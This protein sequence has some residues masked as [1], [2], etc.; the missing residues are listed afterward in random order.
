[1]ERREASGQREAAEIA[2]VIPEE[3]QVGHSGSSEP[4]SSADGA[5]NFADE[6]ERHNAPAIRREAGTLR[7]QNPHGYN[8][9]FEGDDFSPRSGES[10]DYDDD[11]DDDDG[12][13]SDSEE[14]EFLRRSEKLQTSLSEPYAPLSQQGALLYGETITFSE[15]NLV[16]FGG[17]LV[18]GPQYMQMVGALCLATAPVVLLTVIFRNCLQGGLM[19]ATWLSWLATAVTLVWTSVT[20]PAIIPKRMEQMHTNPPRIR[21]YISNKETNIRFCATCEIYRGPRSHHC[22]ICGNCVDQYDHHC[23]WTGTCIGAGNYHIFLYFL[24]TLHFEAAFV[25]IDATVATINLSR[26]NNISVNEALKDLY[27]IPI[28]LY[29][30][31]FAAGFSITGLMLFHW[32]LIVRNLTTA[33]FLKCVYEVE[34]DNPW[35][36]GV[37]NNIVAKFSGWCDSRTLAWNYEA[38]LVK[39]IVKQE[40]GLLTEERE[41][42]L[43]AKR[44][45]LRRHQLL[46]QPHPRHGATSD[47]QQT[48]REDERAFPAPTIAGPNTGLFL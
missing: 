40:L 18:L 21:Q 10:A 30:F 12:I 19:A 32:F 16:F 45:E 29:F 46:S 17:S 48:H 22:G 41:E 25:V 47:E 31:I 8:E 7:P 33:E 2:I 28:V 20:N 1:M 3:A 24:H 37:W 26:S 14:G 27:Y 5:D 15:H 6:L 34:T 4:R 23:P 38:M 11:G 42:R 9:T 36:L 44:V 35:D 39:E 43:R 13:L